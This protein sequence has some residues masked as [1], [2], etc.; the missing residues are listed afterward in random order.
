MF[1]TRALLQTAITPSRQPYTRTVRRGRPN[2]ED[3]GSLSRSLHR[4]AFEVGA[5]GGRSHLLKFQ[6]LAEMGKEFRC[7][8]GL[9]EPFVEKISGDQDLGG[10]WIENRRRIQATQT[11]LPFPTSIMNTMQIQ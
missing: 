4:S 3:L 1:S 9:K 10:N 5:L 8:S 6:W 11:L 2:G 7:I